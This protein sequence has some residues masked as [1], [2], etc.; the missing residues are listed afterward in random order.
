MK[1]LDQTELGFHCR[2]QGY[3]KTKM[4]P[5]RLEVQN[6]PAPSHKYRDYTWVNFFKIWSSFSPVRL[7]TAQVT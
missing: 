4:V 3:G 5:L 7:H 2:V 1:I 6:K